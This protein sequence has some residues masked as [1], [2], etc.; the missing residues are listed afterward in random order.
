MA[1]AASQE[2][3]RE[4]LGAPSKGGQPMTPFGRRVSPY[5]RSE[6]NAATTYLA[7]FPA[8]GQ[9]YTPAAPGRGAIVRTRY[10]LPL[11]QPAEAVMLALFNLG[12]QEVLVLAVLGAGAV[13]VVLAVVFFSRKRDE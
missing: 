3:A 12:L 2:V 13:A 8:F 10:R 1:R 11:V 6:S 4:G 9:W 7:F 5:G